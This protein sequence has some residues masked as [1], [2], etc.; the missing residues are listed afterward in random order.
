MGKWKGTVAKGFTSEEFKEYVNS[1]EWGE[2][3]PGFIVLHNTGEPCLEN[4][5]NGLT[6][7]HILGLASYYRNELGWPAGPHLFIDDHKIWV[8]TP[9]T[10]SGVHAPS[11][12]SI[13]IGVEML[14]DFDKEEFNSGRGA[15]VQENSVA[16]VGI[17]SY[18]LGINPNTMRLHREDPKT[19]HHCPGD[20]VDKADFIAKVEEYMANL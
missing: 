12:N 3:F 20:G 9:L 16:A 17:L 7:D 4:R 15:L 14:G 13:S 10:T 1:L 8:L 19:T 5:P 6:K 2:W 11:W 18:V